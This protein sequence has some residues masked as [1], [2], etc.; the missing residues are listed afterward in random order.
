[1]KFKNLEDPNVLIMCAGKGSRY[2]RFEAPKCLLP[3]SRDKGVILHRAIDQLRTEELHDIT[4]VVSDIKREPF[5]R[6]KRMIEKSLDDKSINIHGV[7]GPIW[8]EKELL[9]DFF[10]SRSLFKNTFVLLGD[11]V[12]EHKALK[13]ILNESFD[14]MMFVGCWGTKPEIF[15]L[16]M[17]E[18]G[19]KKITSL[20]D[21]F[22]NRLSPVTS[23][24]FGKMWSLYHGIEPDH[25]L[26]APKLFTPKGYIADIDTHQEW[27]RVVKTVRDRKI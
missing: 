17:N 5:I 12:M 9:W 22:P 14:D 25:Q 15:A 24:R 16:L 7:G 20:D 6:N 3:V 27:M 8:G 13:E 11:V 26:P 1:M 4:V 10:G 21:P 23:W 19:V 18:V 2:G